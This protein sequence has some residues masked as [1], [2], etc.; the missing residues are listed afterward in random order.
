MSE[1]NEQELIRKVRQLVFRRFQGDYK[2][3][4]DHYARKRERSGSI[5]T[6][7][8]NELLKDADIGN[9][10]TRGAWVSGIIKKLDKNG[11]GFI[12]FSELQWMEQSRFDAK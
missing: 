10:L 3:A 7:E 1:S 4:F 6:D 5:D 12:S 2:R 8:L 9:G 11:D